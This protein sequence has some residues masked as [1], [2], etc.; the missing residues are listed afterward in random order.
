[1]DNYI[2]TQIEREEREREY[3]YTFL[4]IIQWLGYSPGKSEDL[5][6]G[7]PLTQKGFEPAQCSNHVRYYPVS[8]AV[9]LLNIA[10]WK[11]MKGRYAGD[12]WGQE[13]KNKLEGRWLNKVTAG[14]K[15]R[16]DIGI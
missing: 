5:G 16:G 2:V 4:Q 7:P 1:M 11:A 3:S 15:G 9:F 13:E 6:S 14:L 12:M 10:S 8:S